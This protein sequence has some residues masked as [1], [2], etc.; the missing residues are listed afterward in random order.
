MKSA[1]E[2][3]QQETNENQQK[4]NEI[5]KSVSRAIAYLAGSESRR[6]AQK[7]LKEQEDKARRQ[8]ITQG[9]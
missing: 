3:H 7:E 6:E 2:Q 8:F 4:M 5:L 1:N 9:K